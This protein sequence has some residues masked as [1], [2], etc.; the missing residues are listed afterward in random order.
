MF[1]ER[2]ANQ[3]TGRIE[4]WTAEWIP[5]PPAEK[6]YLEKVCDETEPNPPT[7]DLTTEIAVCWADD[8]TMG[9]IAVSSPKMLGYFK[10]GEGT[11]AE[12]PCE[13]IA[14][15]KFRNGA[16][17]FWCRTHQKHWG[18]KADLESLANTGE[19]RC[20]NYIQPM[21]YVLNPE[22]IHLGKHAEVGIW[23]SL[24]AAIASKPIEK[25]KPRIH[26]HLRDEMEGAKHVDG[27]Y[28]AISIIYDQE[29]DL[30]K[31]KSIQ[32]VN[33]TPPAALE[34][35][36]GL[37]QDKEM[38]CINC[39]SCGFPHLD[40]GSFA[41]TPHRKHFC[42]A[43]GRDNTWSKEP[44]VST[45]L[46]PLHDFFLK[47]SDKASPDRTLDLDQY[48]ADHDFRVWASTPAI[49][50]T[51]DRPQEVGIHVHVEND[52]GRIIDD[53]YSEVIYQGKALSR[54]KLFQKM[55]DNA[56]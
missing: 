12:L 24:P 28:N 26:V 11:D 44:I 51:A 32:R 3:K 49:V 37:E 23:C 35:L 48:T 30:F 52:G 5:G 13:V 34:F 45:P 25:R 46:K 15:G 7:G 20:S 14:A 43:C 55:L 9:N 47:N 2:R 42:A 31:S 40:M 22:T 54:E 36:I 33:I 56:S 50:W 10:D 53:T 39:I 8:R 19:I 21:H 18:V 38:D 29:S 16:D 17:R 1:I 27:D 4:F 6:V 41:E